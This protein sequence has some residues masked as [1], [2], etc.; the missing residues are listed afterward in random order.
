VISI[1]VVNWNTGPL[2]ERCVAALVGGPRVF[3]VVLVDNASEDFSLDFVPRLRF[4]LT[5]LRNATNV[6]FAAGCNQGWRSS[7]GEHVLFLNP[8]TESR[9]GAVERLE[10]VLVEDEAVW[11]A[12]GRL[13]GPDAAVQAGFNV[14]ALP[15]V[16]SVAAEMLLLD[17]LWPGNPWTR[18]YRMSDWDLASRRDVEQPAAACLMVR[19]S[20]LTELGGFDESFQPAWFEDVDLCRRI[21][22][23]GGRIV[24]EPAAEFL[25]HGG[26]SLKHLARERFLRYYHGNQLRYFRKHQGPADEARVRRLVHWGMLLRAGLSLVHPLV[27]NASRAAA[28]RTFWRAARHFRQT[29]TAA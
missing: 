7:R 4:P 17:E 3:E 24:F 21:R 1:V 25:H 6:G 19:R 15:T 22:D 2:L 12:G 14:R 13:V 26:A 16:A 10:R 9:A 28:A 18:R 8:D 27:P 29:G 20:V 5:L 11:A 23:A